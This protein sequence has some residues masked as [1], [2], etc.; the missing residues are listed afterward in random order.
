MKWAHRGPLDY[1]ALHPCSHHTRE[2]PENQGPGERRAI[3]ARLGSRGRQV[4]L[5]NWGLGDP[6]DH[7]V[8]RDK[9]APRECPEQLG[10]LELLDL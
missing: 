6:L 9:K 4:T 2:C 7:R 8:P 3:L 1:L 10:A 5:E